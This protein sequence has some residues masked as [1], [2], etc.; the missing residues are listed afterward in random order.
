MPWQGLFLTVVA[1]LHV[2]QALRQTAA[3]P[4]EALVLGDVL[5][6]VQSVLHEGVLVAEQPRLPLL[7]NLHLQGKDKQN[8][9]LDIVI[10]RPTS[11]IRCASR[12]GAENHNAEI[13]WKLKKNRK[14]EIL[15]AVS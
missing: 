4:A 9:P 14:K 12:P 10:C 2:N 5:A 6:V 3:F 7:A 13:I 8:D 15:Q 1:V 11:V